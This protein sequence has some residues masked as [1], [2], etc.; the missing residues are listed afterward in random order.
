MY[1]RNGRHII[2]SH[3]WQSPPLPASSLLPLAQRMV[4]TQVSKQAASPPLLCHIQTHLGTHAGS[5]YTCHWSPAEKQMHTH[6]NGQA[7]RLMHAYAGTHLHIDPAPASAFR[8]KLP[9]RARAM[10]RQMHPSTMLTPQGATLYGC[11]TPQSPSTRS[12]TH[13]SPLGTTCTCNT[14][15]TLLTL[16]LW[17][18]KVLH[19]RLLPSP[20]QIFLIYITGSG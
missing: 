3:C 6:I 13:S 17:W 15:A 5:I 18:I 19:L 16:H 1:G 4:P 11:T 14:D 7:H 20:K 8:N 2:H 10:R 9:Q 12:C